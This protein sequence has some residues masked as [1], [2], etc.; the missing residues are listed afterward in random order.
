MSNKFNEKWYLQSK[1]AQCT[2]TGQTDADGNA[3]TL[4]TL[5]AAIE[6][7]GYTLESH[8]KA[9]ADKEGTQAYTQ[10]IF[11]EE[12][13][14]Q[15]KLAQ[16]AKVGELDADGNAYTRD[17]LIQAIEKAGMT[18]EQHF[19]RY[20]TKE[21]TSA[22]PY[23]N[24]TEYL[25]AKLHQLQNNADAS[26]RAQWAN[27]TAEDVAK[28]I[29]DAGMS[30]EEHYMRYGSKEVDKDG[31]LIN[32]SNAFDANAYAAAKLAELQKSDPENWADKTAQDVVDAINKVGL[33]PV[34]H[35]EKYG[36]DEAAESGVAMVQTVPVVDR[37][38]N[39]PLRDATGENVPSNYNPST[40]APKDVDAAE[41]SAV[42]K[43][44][45]M[46]TISDSQKPADPVATPSDSGYVAPPAN[47]V[48]T[49]ANPVVLVQETVTNADGKEVTVS[50]YGISTGTKTDSDGNTVATVAAISEDGT[51]DPDNAIQTT[52]K[53]KDGTVTEATNIEDAAGNKASSTTETK[54]N[55]DSNEKVAVTFA[56]GTGAGKA[57]S[58]V[59][60][61]DGSKTVTES[62]STTD[63][64]GKTVENSTATTTKDGEVT[65]TTES[66]STT[67][68][69]AN[70]TTTT[71]TEAK[72][73][74]ADGSTVEVESTVTA[75][76]DGTVT[77]SESTST[78]TDAD[79][80]KTVV[81]ETVSNGTTTTKTT[82][83][84]EDGNKTSEETHTE[85]SGGGGSGGGS[86]SSSDSG[87]KDDAVTLKLSKVTDATSALD[88]EST[89]ATLSG[90]D[91]ADTFDLDTPP[92]SGWTKMATIS[93]LVVNGKDGADKIS[94]TADLK[95]SMTNLATLT[96]NGGNG[97]NTFEL[98]K[99]PG[100]GVAV[101]VKGGLDKD[102][103]TITE[104]PTGTL[105]VDG[106][107]NTDTVNI[108]GDAN[109]SGA[110]FTSIETL[111]IGANNVTLSAAQFDDATMSITG[112]GTATLSDAYTGTAAKDI[113]VNL[114]LAD[115]TNS[116]IIGDASGKTVTGGS[117]D[118][119]FTISA[120]SSLSGT[121]LDG[122]NGSD[123]LDVEGEVS[124]ADATVSG[125]EAVKLA[126]GA[127]L[128]M[129]T[130][131]YTSL[132]LATTAPTV[133]NAATITFSDALTSSVTLK[134]AANLT[135]KLSDSAD[136]VKLAADMTD[137]AISNFGADDKIDAESITALQG[138]Y[139]ATLTGT[140]WTLTNKNVYLL[141]S[142]FNVANATLAS[143]AALVV[144]KEDD[145]YQ[146][147][148][149]TNSGSTTSTPLG[150]I[151]LA[152]GAT[153]TNETF[154]RIQD[155]STQTLSATISDEGVLGFEGVDK[156]M[157]I[158]L[159]AGVPTVQV[160]SNNVDIKDSTGAVTTAATI[161]SID[162]SSG[163][164]DVTVGISGANG[165]S[166]ANGAALT[167]TKASANT[168]VTLT[169]DKADNVIFDSNTA[170]PLVDTTAAFGAG[171]SLQGTFDLG[172]TAGNTVTD[173]KMALNADG[174]ILTL[175]S[176]GTTATFGADGH[177]AAFGADTITTVKVEGE[178]VTADLTNANLATAASIT[179][180]LSYDGAQTLVSTDA[181][182]QK[183]SAVTGATAGDTIKVSDATFS[184]I[185]AN[186][187]IY[188]DQ[189]VGTIDSTNTGSTITLDV[190]DDAD[191]S[192]ATIGGTFTALDVAADKTLTLSAAELNQFEATGQ[193]V[194]VAAGGTVALAG[195]SSVA[196]TVA[197]TNTWNST[198]VL[199]FGENTSASID[200]S[201][202]SAAETFGVVKGAALTQLDLTASAA[203]QLTIESLTGK[204]DTTEVN[205]KGVGAVALTKIADIK[206][207]N[208]DDAVNT[209]TVGELDGLTVNL[210]KGADVL[211]VTGSSRTSGITFDFAAGDS[212][213]PAANTYD[214]IT[215]FKAGADK[216]KFDGVSVAT[217]V[218]TASA[219]AAKITT[220]KAE[221]DSSDN[222]LAK[223]LTA[224]ATS[225]GTTTGASAAWVENG[226]AYIFI[227]GDT[228]ADVSAQDVLIQ[229]AGVTSLTSLTATDGVLS[230]Q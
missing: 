146:L 89:P 38:A 63:A 153:I 175:G 164:G 158:A 213:L 225:V 4:S 149:V 172:T 139:F 161:S 21:G 24:T 106:G 160:N 76:E 23:F 52:T 10:S 178:G 218:A 168:T 135:F 148:Y 188:T 221:F 111:N 187:G 121:T 99:D 110:T 82:T 94:V 68:P 26:V 67:V 134:G 223:E 79:G 190:D 73:T 3:Y 145:V 142:S 173:A 74:N 185:T 217:D 60:N 138:G 102:T 88:D 118:D 131:Q 46:A 230:I 128:T 25:E 165:V 182:Q 49:N 207:V 159:A 53:T 163:V 179:L 143:G 29:S 174:T 11:D 78:T 20:S 183:M 197:G 105:T 157:T 130:D 54:P 107:A 196:L 6:N 56:D 93:D 100:T 208:G 5:K 180:D 198:G 104:V 33:T 37:V 216:I 151:A 112:T 177:Q 12:Y 123:T 229:L 170:A 48:D 39:D 209:I 181:V 28:A 43:P 98:T 147:N 140:S 199:D 45:D 141:E 44:C 113:S 66:E 71:T 119:T 30:A 215:G 32:P 81:E 50:E 226:N 132:G 162:L 144:S 120:A 97:E 42:T 211:T 193:S 228:S 186:K 195:N 137:V 57:S 155:P 2:K 41:A 65:S 167:I 206:A 13:Y 122:G 7:A 17:T 19:Q 189:F 127:D 95:T 36:Q 184:I 92:A 109:V 90:G 77:K 59:T 171:D 103:V 9:F 55:G 156:A 70:G 58:T 80:A 108:A 116:I 91:N 69:N 152:S 126:S 101:T 222:D 34:S 51:A 166:A 64:D 124:I 227:N 86:S 201:T 84:D 27:K 31:N 114:T 219:G 220:G 202:A 8:Y 192:A 133:T 194:T 212:G 154:G 72:T 40:P 62:A 15:S 205:V 203:N 96:L 61:E 14:L 22:N 85:G 18:V 83:Y 87:A 136:T 47:V 176:T 117:N 75:K 1:L 125:F 191:L 150:T 169:A 16:L 35:Y 224:V 210:G 115:Q 204:A 200:A 129:T 214:Q